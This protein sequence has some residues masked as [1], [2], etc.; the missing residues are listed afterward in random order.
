MEDILDSNG[1]AQ[2]LKVETKTIDY[3]VR[4]R[5]IPIFFVGRHVRFLKE[6]ILEW[7]RMNEV[8]P[9]KVIGKLQEAEN[10]RARKS[11][12]LPGRQVV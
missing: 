11:R 3:L 2:Y 4:M 6:A 7:A 9:D 12:N 1:L 5:R 10:L 8:F